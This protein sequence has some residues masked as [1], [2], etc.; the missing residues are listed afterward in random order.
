LISTSQEKVPDVIR[1]MVEFMK[2]I[3]IKGS[4]KPYDAANY[5][6]QAVTAYGGYQGPTN[7]FSQAGPPQRMPPHRGGNLEPFDSH[8]GGFEPMRNQSY[9]QPPFGGAPVGGVS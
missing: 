7:S 2:D 9:S 8:R 5:N 6:P 1:Q 4:V 3:Q